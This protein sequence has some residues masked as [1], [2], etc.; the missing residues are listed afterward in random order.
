MSS[1][2]ITPSVSA[3]TDFLADDEEGDDEEGT[4]TGSSEEDEAKEWVA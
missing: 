1:G 2:D 3:R 4:T